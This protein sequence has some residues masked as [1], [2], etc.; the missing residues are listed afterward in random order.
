MSFL[1]AI[2]LSAIPSD[3]GFGGFDVNVDDTLLASV[4]YQQHCV[5]IYSVIDQTAAP[6]IVGT[7]GIRGSAHGQLD[8]PAFVCFVHRNGMDTL[9][10]VDSGN[11]RIVEVSASG[12]FLRAIAVKKGSRPFGIAERDGVIAVSLCHANAVVLLQYESGAVKPEVIIGSGTGARGRG[13]GELFHPYGV[14]FTLDGCY[15]LVADCGNHRVCKFSAAS[16]A[17]IAHVAT[18]AANEMYLPTDVLQCEDGSIVVAHS[19]SVVCVGDDGLSLKNIM[20]PS[21]D[22]CLTPLSLSYSAS[23]DVVV[24]KLCTKGVFLIQNA[25]MVSRRH[26]WL[27]ALSC[28]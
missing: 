20:F 18:K 11:D 3:G 1:P 9:L 12:V 13:N 7:A 6:F 17:F 21:G 19:G 4:D 15:I 10:I 27:S 5:R 23:S 24:V 8:N 22:L 14:A 2:L 28:S 26:A 25:W 16:G